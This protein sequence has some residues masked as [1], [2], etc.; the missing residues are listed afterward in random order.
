M[1][2]REILRGEDE[3][4]GD[5]ER[6]DTNQHFDRVLDNRISIVSKKVQSQS[7]AAADDAVFS[8]ARS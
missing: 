4:S 7:V 2:Q 3:T 8:L 5:M 6:L 1:T